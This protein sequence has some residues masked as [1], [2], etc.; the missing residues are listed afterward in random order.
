[1]PFKQAGLSVHRVQTVSG[2]ADPKSTAAVFED[3]PH[4][5]VDQAVRIFRIMEESCEIAGI[6]FKPVKATF[7]IEIPDK[8]GPHPK[9]TLVVLIKGPY[10]V[11]AQACRI[12]CVVAV[13][14][15]LACFSIQQIKSSVVA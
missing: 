13:V 7:V 9:R 10:F 15:E 2:R 8:T 12:L 4:F 1:M 3:G 11:A 5:V 14:C 6:P